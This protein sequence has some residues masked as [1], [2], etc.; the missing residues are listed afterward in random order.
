MDISI[1]ISK[2]KSLFKKKIKPELVLIMGKAG[3]GKSSKMALIVRESIKLGRPVYCSHHV[4]GAIQVNAQDL[5]KYDLNDCD[6]IIDEAQLEY[7]NR[8]FKS[9]TK[10]NKYFFSNFRHHNCRVYILSQ[11]FEDLD[12]KI[13]RQAQ[14]IYIMQPFLPGI[15]LMQ[16][17]RVKFGI[18]EDETAII[19]KYR[20]SILD[21]RLNW[22]RPAW[23]YFN[24][25]SRPELPALE[26]NLWGEPPL[27]KTLKDRILAFTKKD[28]DDPWE[29][30]ERLEESE[31][32]LLELQSSD[33]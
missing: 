7:D 28:Y 25:Y 12:V 17:V 14:R 2:F 26:P 29:D 1:L 8:D 10:H 30:D 33:K 9:F 6:I 21:I 13:R 4:L 11:S 15:L 18:S 32:M 5:G 27:E 20:S 22:S 31:Q 3:S 23:K 19:T 24:S 16:K